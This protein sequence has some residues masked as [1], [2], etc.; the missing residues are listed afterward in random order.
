MALGPDYAIICLDAIP[1]EKQRNTVRDALIKARKTIV[2]VT[3]P[4]VSILSVASHSIASHLCM[5]DGRILLQYGAFGERER[6]STAASD[7]APCTRS[8]AR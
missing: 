1:D 4:Q 3:K 6:A 2:E 7:V 8:S 5:S